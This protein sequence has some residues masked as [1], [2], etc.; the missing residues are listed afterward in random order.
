MECYCIRV[1]IILFCGFILQT[2]VVGKQQ[3]PCYFIFGDSLVDNGNN[4]HLVTFAKATY[5]PH[6]IDFDSGPTGRFCNGRNFADLTGLSQGDRITFDEQLE[7]HEMTLSSISD[8]LGGPHS[9]STYLHKCFY[10]IGF[11]SN[12]YLN[13]YFLTSVYDTNSMFTVKE[14]TKALIKQYRSQILKLYNYGA[15]KVAL[16]GLGPIGCTPFELSRHSMDGSC[17]EYINKGVQLFNHRLKLLVDELNNDTSLQDAKFIYL[18]FYDMTMEVI[19]QPAVFGFRV[20]NKACCGMGLNN[21]ALTCLPFEVP[22]PD[23]NKYFFWDAYHSTE[24]AN[25]IASRRT[26]H[27]L[28]QSDA[29]PFD[30]YHLVQL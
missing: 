1:M 21:G 23:R 6:G 25:K 12:D 22:C 14:F 17:V 28:N 18:N 20:V 15:R 4:N 29:Y 3:V 16:H 7:N 26:Y 13:N 27:A 2:W 9:A 5:L 30:I 10:H 11:G 8:I 19:Q 24:A